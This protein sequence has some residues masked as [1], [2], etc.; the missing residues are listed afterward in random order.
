MAEDVLSVEV[1][2]IGIEP[3]LRIALRV[4]P[5]ATVAQAVAASDIAARIAESGRVAAGQG[6]LDALTVA[7]HGRAATPGDL[8]HDDDRI[9]LLPA[10]TVDPKVARQR[11]ADH[12]RR[13][14]GER[15]WTPDRQRTTQAPPKAR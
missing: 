12:R 14:A 3:P 15:R 8:L 1:V 4:A 5:G 11:R 2:W 13:L 10:L 7:V 6:P 9:E